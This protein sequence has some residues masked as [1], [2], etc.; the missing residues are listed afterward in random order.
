[1]PCLGYQK[2]DCPHLED[3]LVIRMVI[4]HY[5]VWY[6]SD[7]TMTA[8]GTVRNA[9]KGQLEESHQSCTFAAAIVIAPVY[10]HNLH[11]PSHRATGRGIKVC[12]ETKRQPSLI[13]SNYTK[14]R[15]RQ[16]REKSA[17][18][19]QKSWRWKR[20]CPVRQDELDVKS[21]RYRVCKLISL[22]NSIPPVSCV[23]RIN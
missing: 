23:W 15:D 14:T 3:G 7:C 11:W 1:M 16:L 21:S 22:K 9:V 13:K 10:D 2:T 4:W 12:D 5:I 19:E 6:A 8:S 17:P 18:S 20:G